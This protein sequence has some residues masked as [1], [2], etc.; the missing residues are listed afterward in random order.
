[1]KMMEL[2]SLCTLGEISMGALI[3]VA[4]KAAL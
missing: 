2:H 1:V 4:E 3:R